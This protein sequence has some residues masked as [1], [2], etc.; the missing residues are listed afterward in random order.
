MAVVCNMTTWLAE[1]NWDSL[2]LRRKYLSIV[3]MY[4][5]IIGY[6]DA[7][8]SKYDDIVGPS[9]TCSNHNYKIRPKA[10]HTNYFKYSLFNRYI[11]DW[12]SLSS[13]VLSSTSINSFKA[14]F[15][16][17]SVTFITGF[18]IICFVSVILNL[19]KEGS[20]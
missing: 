8:C 6:C 14:F 19:Y 1:I 9:R 13:S 12:N 7:D 4:K 10:A 18:P 17:L 3:Q 20:L 11:N 15:F 16:F 5:I 2:E